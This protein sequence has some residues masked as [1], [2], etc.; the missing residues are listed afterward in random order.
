MRYTG[1]LKTGTIRLL[2]KVGAVILLFIG[3]IALL[4]PLFDDEIARLVTVLAG[5]LLILTG[6]GLYAVVR[7][8][9]RRG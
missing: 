1:T 7:R 5:G 9:G 6:V 2:G 3:I 8:S 4:S